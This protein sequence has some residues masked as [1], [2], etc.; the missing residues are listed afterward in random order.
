MAKAPKSSPAPS[1]APEA[2]DVYEVTLARDV[3]EGDLKLLA[4]DTHHLQKSVVDT[5]PAGS[6][7]QARKL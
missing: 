7:K 2:D 5:L 3:R 1:P 4:R 6:V